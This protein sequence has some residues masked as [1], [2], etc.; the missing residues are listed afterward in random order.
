MG[1]G[2]VVKPP[3][4]VFVG[5]VAVDANQPVA[6]E[7]LVRSFEDCGPHN[8]PQGCDTHDL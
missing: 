1:N 8:L 7:D 3:L 5:G 2:L 4:N 6:D